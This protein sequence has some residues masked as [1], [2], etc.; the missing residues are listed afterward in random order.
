MEFK[1]ITY[2][3]LTLRKGCGGFK[4][5]LFAAFLQRFKIS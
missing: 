1:H 4:F 5:S 2:P 3:Q